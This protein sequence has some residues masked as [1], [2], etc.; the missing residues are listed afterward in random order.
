VVDP[1]VAEREPRRRYWDAMAFTTLGS[2]A[3]VGLA[4]LFAVAALAKL[5]ARAT[6]TRSFAELGLPAPRV[7][8]VLVPAVELLIAVALVLDP[9]VGSVAALVTLAFFTA[10]LAKRLSEGATAPCA[11]FGAASTHPIR[12][13][14]LARN[15]GL[16]AL[17]I[18]AL[19]AP[20]PLDLTAAV[21]VAIFVLTAAASTGVGRRAAGRAAGP[22]PPPVNER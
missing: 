8:A 9:P 17:G 7:A 1:G 4:A 19:A 12:P 11:C 18:V 21:A 3:A 15:A 14:D 22:A 20:R 2:V 6:T 13:R 10:F 5:R 16:L